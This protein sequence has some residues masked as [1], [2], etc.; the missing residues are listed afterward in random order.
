MG[1]HWDIEKNSSKVTTTEHVSFVNQALFV[2][3]NII[4]YTWKE[5]SMYF[6][7]KKRRNMIEAIEIL[8]FFS[9]NQSTSIIG[10]IVP[11]LLCL[12]FQAD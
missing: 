6:C 3:N 2:C 4:S 1:L 5:G 8:Q 9:K 11:F 7:K 10:A 12:L